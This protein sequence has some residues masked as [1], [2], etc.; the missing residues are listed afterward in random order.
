MTETVLFFFFIHCCL[1]F[2]L[3]MRWWGFVVFSSFLGIDFVNT[4]DLFINP[5]CVDDIRS[6]HLSIL[7]LF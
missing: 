1:L 4:Y 6:F 5:G 3:E 2:F 7:F